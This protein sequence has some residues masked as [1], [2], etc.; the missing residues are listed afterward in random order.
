MVDNSYIWVI[1]T[2]V[3]IA[4]VIKAKIN[5]DK[6]P[7]EVVKGNGE[8]KDG[9]Q[10]NYF[11]AITATILFPF[12]GI[13]YLILLLC[14]NNKENEKLADTLMFINIFLLSIVLLIIVG[15]LLLFG[16]CLV[17]LLGGGHF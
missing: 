7:H 17:S 9:H 14:F 15:F 3:A 8:I 1:L 16:T 10:G 6:N 13:P 2:I 4:L 11:I 12:L 5:W